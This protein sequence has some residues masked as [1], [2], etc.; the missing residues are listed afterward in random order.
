MP[1]R[2]TRDTPLLQTPPLLP[3]WRFPLLASSSRACLPAPW[4]YALRS[5]PCDISG[6]PSLHLLTPR[7]EDTRAGTHRKDNLADLLNLVRQ[8][9]HG[10]AASFQQVARRLLTRL[11]ESPVPFFS[12]LPGL[13]VWEAAAPVCFQVSSVK[14]DCIGAYPKRFFPSLPPNTPPGRQLPVSP[15]RV[16][17]T[18]VTATY[19]PAYFVPFSYSEV[20]GYIYA[21]PPPRPGTQAYQIPTTKRGFAQFLVGQPGH[22]LSQAHSG[23]RPG[24]RAKHGHKQLA[25]SIPQQPPICCRAPPTHRPVLGPLP[26]SHTLSS[27]TSPLFPQVDITNLPPAIPIVVGFSQASQGLIRLGS[28]STLLSGPS[29]GAHSCL[30]LP[31]LI[32]LVT[33]SNASPSTGKRLAAPITANMPTTKPKLE[34]L[35]TP[36]TATFPSEASSASTATPLSAIQFMCKPD[37]DFIKTPISPP[38]AYTD[39][40]SKA[41]SLGSPALT[42][43]LNEPLDSASASASDQSEASSKTD[44]SSPLSSPDPTSTTTSKA[45]PPA[46]ATVSAPASSYPSLTPMSA[47]P[48]GAAS[49]P[50]LKLPPS[51]AISNFDPPLSA[52]TVRSPFSARSVHPV[53]DWDA[54]LKARFSDLKKHKTSRTSVRHIREVVTRTVTYTPK[55]EPAP[56]GKRRKVE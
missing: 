39:F 35:A 37:P 21:R 1:T 13:P 34:K 25:P 28:T 8:S 47:P 44:D 41:M 19:L 43:P 51:P 10:R 48:T 53:F 50:S 55:M 4:F 24:P 12:S 33:P 14:S 22:L 32:L 20:Y 45:S 27:W 11:L 26:N 23:D 2:R 30:A 5:F 7:A 38:L 36:I 3:G 42:S 40:L 18:H 9:C 52:S 54:A 29:V 56:R 31:N 16:S 49:F 6:H 17:R 15:R 46:S